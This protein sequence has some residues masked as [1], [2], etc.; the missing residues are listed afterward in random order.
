MSPRRFLI[1]TTAVSAALAAVCSLAR[2]V[3]AQ[4]P[5]GYTGTPFMG[6]PWPI[7][8]RIDFENFDEGAEDGTHEVSSP[9]RPGVRRPSAVGGGASP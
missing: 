5:A 8:G 1:R 7:P 6:T 2:P 3:Q 4:V 9:D